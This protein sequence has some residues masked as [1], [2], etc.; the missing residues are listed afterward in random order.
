MASVGFGCNGDRGS[1]ESCCNCS[2]EKLKMDDSI[3]DHR[4]SVSENTNG[5]SWS[6]CW[7][8]EDGSVSRLNMGQSPHTSTLF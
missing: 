8:T 1:E 3:S 5:S 6:H 4:R 7:D 2:T